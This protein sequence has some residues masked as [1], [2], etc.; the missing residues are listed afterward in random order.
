MTKKSIQPASDPLYRRGTKTSNSYEKFC[1]I[2]ASL[3]GVS[4]RKQK[5]AIALMEG[6]T[7]IKEV[8]GRVIRGIMRMLWAP[9]AE[10]AERAAYG[11]WR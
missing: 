5:K 10:A 1:G 4:T 8:K 6:P 3:R 2:P 11:N 9:Y 7:P